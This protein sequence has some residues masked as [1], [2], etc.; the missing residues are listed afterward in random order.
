MNPFEMVAII[1]IAALIAGVLRSRHKTAAPTS[2]LA[3][4]QSLAHAQ[5]QRIAQLEA[6]IQA[7]EAVVGDTQYELRRQFKDL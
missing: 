4:L 2:T 5:Q 7:L 1:V 6:R 3:E